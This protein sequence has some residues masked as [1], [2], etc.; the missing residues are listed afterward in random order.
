MMTVEGDGRA[1]Q[2]TMRERS[3]TMRRMLRAQCQQSSR[4]GRRGWHRGGGRGGGRPAVKNDRHINN[5]S[6]EAAGYV[7]NDD[8]LTGADDVCIEGDDGEF[9]EVED[10]AGRG[11]RWLWRTTVAHGGSMTC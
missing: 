11:M 4:G 3:R 2:D 8:G 7:D 9:W 6:G 1:K 10:G 5:G